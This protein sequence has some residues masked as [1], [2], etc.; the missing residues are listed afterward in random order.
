MIKA[1]QAGYI[2]YDSETHKRNGHYCVIEMIIPTLPYIQL[3]VIGKDGL[4][5]AHQVEN[6][7][8]ITG[9]HLYNA[10][11]GDHLG[12]GDLKPL[13][14]AY[15]NGMLEGLS[16]QMNYRYAIVAKAFGEGIVKLT[17]RSE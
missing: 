9:Y 5:S 11:S 15:P 6:I 1:Y 4:I 10:P 14:T 3:M 12:A 8:E 13:D 16:E 17:G 2:K 7:T